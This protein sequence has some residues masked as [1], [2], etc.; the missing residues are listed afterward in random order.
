MDDERD[1]SSL[2]GADGLERQW[3]GASVNSTRSSQPEGLR[4]RRPRRRASP[5]RRAR[6]RGSSARAPRSWSTLSALPS[7][8]L[9]PLRTATSDL[10]RRTG[11]SS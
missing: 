1:V 5:C 6:A 10:A 4:T 8:P 2:T 9:Y 7:K 3:L 11:N